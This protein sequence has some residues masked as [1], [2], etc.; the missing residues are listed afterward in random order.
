MTAGSAGRCQGYYIS[1]HLQANPGGALSDR[2]FQTS[3]PRVCTLVAWELSACTSRRCPQ[4]GTRLG[5][6]GRGMQRWPDPA[7]PDPRCQAPEL[8]YCDLLSH[9]EPSRPFTPKPA[10]P[11][12]E[13]LSPSG[14]QVIEAGVI[15]DSPPLLTS[16]LADAPEAEPSSGVVQAQPPLA[17]IAG[18]A[19]RHCPSACSLCSPSSAAHALGRRDS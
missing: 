10:P 16:H 7:A 12:T 19:S 8:A 15:P 18:V 11:R 4:G 17:W 3:P 14:A 9:E 1:D 13:H 5:W 2:G 6:K